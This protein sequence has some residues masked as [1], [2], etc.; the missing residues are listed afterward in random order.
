MCH[1]TAAVAARDPDLIDRAPFGVR[2]AD[3]GERQQDIV[4]GQGRGEV[5]QVL[6][7]RHQLVVPQ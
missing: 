6:T 5:G 4:L 3:P 1:E 2:C 7:K